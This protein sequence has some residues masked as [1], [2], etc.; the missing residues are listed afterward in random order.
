M[1]LLMSDKTQSLTAFLLHPLNLSGLNNYKI[2]KL[3]AV[4]R[5]F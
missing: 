2:L 3:Q 4:L 5:L 1:S